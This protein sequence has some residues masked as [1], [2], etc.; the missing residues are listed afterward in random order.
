MQSLLGFWAQTIPAGR[1]S[2]AHGCFG[3]QPFLGVCYWQYF[4]RVCKIAKERFDTRRQG[5]HDHDA[6]LVR[7]CS[8]NI[9]LVT[10]DRNVI[11][12]DNGRPLHVGAKHYH[13]NDQTLI[14]DAMLVHLKEFD[15]GYRRT[16][17]RTLPVV[18]CRSWL[19]PLSTLTEK[20]HDDAYCKV[21]W[22]PLVVAPEQ[23][24]MS[25]AESWG[26]S[27]TGDNHLPE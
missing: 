13:A 7:V 15:F 22:L 26:S 17:S 1:N 8:A 9:V 16:A 21:F 5:R 12:I 2:Q 19:L 3:D 14:R 27:P 10:I 23:A 4:E 25:I 24:P 20:Y 6:H 18:P 11:Q